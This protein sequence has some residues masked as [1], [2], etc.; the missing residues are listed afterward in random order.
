[1]KYRDSLVFTGHRIYPALTLRLQ[2]V[3]VTN[4]HI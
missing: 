1:M 2:G 3:V 4:D